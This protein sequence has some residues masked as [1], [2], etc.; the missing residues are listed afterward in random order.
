MSDSAPRHPEPGTM[1]SFIEGTL[2][3]AELEAFTA[4]LDGCDDCLTVIAE[5]ARYEA[6]RQPQGAAARRPVV[7]WWL[8]AAA[9]V[10]AVATTIPLLRW[11]APGQASPLARLIEAAP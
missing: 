1:V 2:A 4:H 7:R 8:L 3:P 11:D 5:T 6:E 9:A 10:V